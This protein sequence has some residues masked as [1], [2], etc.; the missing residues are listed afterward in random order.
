MG[1]IPN[2]RRKLVVNDPTLLSPTMKQMSVTVRSVLR[3][4]YGGALEP[5]RQQVLVRRLAE[6]GAELAAEVGR[7]QARRPRHVGDRERL[8]VAGVGEVL[9]A[10]EISRRSDS[11]HGREYRRAAQRPEWAA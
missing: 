6:G 2:M 5:S 7:R 11:R 9:A 3:S 10:D 4:R 1:V 8:G